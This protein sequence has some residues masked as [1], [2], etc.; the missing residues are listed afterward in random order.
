MWQEGTKD[1][2][3]GQGTIYGHDFMLE[4]S[5]CHRSTAYS[6]TGKEAGK[7]LGMNEWFKSYKIMLLISLSYVS[8]YSST[9][10]FLF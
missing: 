1:R 2:K 5:V 3:R 10:F 9:A 8:P 6:I 4:K 7:Q